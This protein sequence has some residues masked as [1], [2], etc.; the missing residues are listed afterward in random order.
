MLE[1]RERFS[2][3]T[4]NL[5]RRIDSTEGDTAYMRYRLAVK[6]AALLANDIMMETTERVGTIH[7]LTMGR[8]IKWR[9]EGAEAR[10]CFR[11]LGRAADVGKTARKQRLRRGLRD[12]RKTLS[13][14][15]SK[16]LRVFI[17]SHLPVA[18]AW[19]AQHTGWEERLTPPNREGESA[20]GLFTWMPDPSAFR[21]KVER[22]TRAASNEVRWVGDSWA[23]S[24]PPPKK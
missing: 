5:K 9:G 7:R 16:R 23:E 3:F 18:R 21:R 6:K 17:R 10:A 15:T 1:H 13:Q 11:G 19:A 24:T 8:T 20:Y 14:A 4:Q 2:V 22:V 12:L